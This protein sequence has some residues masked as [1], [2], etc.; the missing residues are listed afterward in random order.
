[1]H[2]ERNN[3]SLPV[4]ANSVNLLCFDLNVTTMFSLTFHMH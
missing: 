1:M 3:Y 2:L 4:I